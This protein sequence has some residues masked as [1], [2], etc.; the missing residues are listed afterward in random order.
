MAI[1]QLLGIGICALLI[2]ILTACILRNEPTVPAQQLSVPSDNYG[3]VLR[4]P[5]GKILIQAGRLSSQKPDV[6][7]YYALDEESFIE[8]LFKDDPRCRLTEYGLSTALPDGRLGLSE[9]CRGRWPEQPIGRDGARYIVAYDWESSAIEQIVVEPLP[10]ESLTFSWNP[11]LTRGVQGIGSLL[12]TITW[13]TPTGMEPMT[14]TIGTGEQSWS[15][16]ENLIVM[17]DYRRGNDRSAEVGI[18]RNPAWSPDG[19]FVAFWASTNVIGRSGMS[20]ARGI[21]GLYLLDPDTLQ[22]R[23]ILNNVRNTGHLIWSPDSQWLLFT[24]DIGSSRN[25]LWLIS[26]DGHTL[27]WV[28]KGAD[29]DLYPPF[30]G[31]NWLNDLEIIATRCLDANCDRS[32]VIKY[33]VSKIVT[34]AQE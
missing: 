11:E 5:N 2:V 21:Y 9:I 23:Q 32:E 6:L 26:V 4:F 15:L 10:Y 13:L 31:W 22:L 7:R 17:D 25:T 1:K 3:T 34:T 28:D 27:Q 19:R 24:G 14:V 8:V 18:A 16:D 12:G 30:N 20:R 33:D 29:F